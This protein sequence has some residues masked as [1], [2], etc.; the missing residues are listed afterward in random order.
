MDKLRSIVNNIQVHVFRTGDHKFH[1]L[2]RPTSYQ[3]C[4]KGPNT[5]KQ[6]CAEYWLKELQKSM[7]K[8]ID[9]YTAEMI[10]KMAL[11][12]I[13]IINLSKDISQWV[14]AILL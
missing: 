13:Q 5:S 9:S 3:E 4:E 7:G 12:V 14:R 10:L 11:S 8:W 1:T 6:Y 2:V